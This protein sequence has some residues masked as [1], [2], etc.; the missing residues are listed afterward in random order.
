[1]VIAAMNAA[2]SAVAP[3]DSAMIFALRIELP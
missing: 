3:A 2:V 1:V